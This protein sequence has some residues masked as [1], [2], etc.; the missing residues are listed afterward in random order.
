MTTSLELT[1]QHSARISVLIAVT[2]QVPTDA[3]RKHTTS[4]SGFGE[5]KVQETV[6]NKITLKIY[7]ISIGI[8]IGHSVSQQ[9]L[10]KP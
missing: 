9:K 1:V 10:P 3:I 4:V 6:E 8:L 7:P 2:K 5:S